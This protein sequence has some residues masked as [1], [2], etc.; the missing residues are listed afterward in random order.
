MRAILGCAAALL[1]LAPAAPGAL[2]TGPWTNAQGDGPITGANTASPVV[3]DGSANSAESEMVGSPFPAVTLANPGDRVEL[4]AAV[5]LAG[6]VNSAAGSGTP[7]TQ[8]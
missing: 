7:R 2:V 3:G 6:T 4:R 1:L 5:T 8:F